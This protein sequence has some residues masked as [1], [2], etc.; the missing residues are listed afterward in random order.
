MPNIAWKTINGYGPY[1]YLQHSVKVGQGHVNSMH[2]AYLGKVGVIAT[3]G[4]T[5]TIR[6]NMVTGTADVVAK[7]QIGAKVLVPG[8]EKKLIAGLKPGPATK[9]KPE[10]IDQIEGPNPAPAPEP[11]KAKAPP[12]K[13][14]P[15]EVVAKDAT[16]QYRTATRKLQD[17]STVY[18]IEG[19]PTDGTSDRGWEDLGFQFQKTRIKALAAFTE[20]YPRIAFKSF[21][22]N[23]TPSHPFLMKRHAT[24]K[25]AG[26]KA[27][28]EQAA[29]KVKEQ[30][31]AAA[32]LKRQETLQEQFRLSPSFKKATVKPATE[33][34]VELEPLTG[35]AFGGL[36]VHKSRDRYSPKGQLYSITHIASG[37]SVASSLPGLAG[38]KFVAWRIAGLTDWTKGEATI[39]NK[40]NVFKAASRIIRE[41]VY[42]D[43]SDLIKG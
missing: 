22:E 37:K 24:M 25:A 16:Y 4:Q 8:I 43:V 41:S 19:R 15:G 28:R 32:L 9:I 27:V 13:P 3:P 7:A 18:F 5:V 29:A 20:R 21:V 33:K 1:A 39:K 42:A 6:A 40:N 34:G 2:I 17:G 36:L 11:I 12:S 31:E 35:V 14:K 26:E 30:G 38:T 10:W 23:V